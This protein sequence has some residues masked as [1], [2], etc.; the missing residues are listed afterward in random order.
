MDRTFSDSESA[1]DH[2]LIHVVSRCR[3]HA[4]IKAASSSSRHRRRRRVKTVAEKSSICLRTRSPSRPV[5]AS[6]ALNPAACS[7]GRG[8]AAKTPVP[9]S[10]G[11][12]MR[13]PAPITVQQTSAGVYRALGA[14]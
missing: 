13:F 6:S 14:L 1:T 12:V 3:P 4:W 5:G 7:L 8:E 2:T 10:D 9:R 11:A